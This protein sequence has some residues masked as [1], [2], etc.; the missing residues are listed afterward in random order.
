MPAAAW[1]PKEA[2]WRP[3]RP[4]IP[5]G[6]SYGPLHDIELLTVVSTGT[7]QPAQRDWLFPLVVCHVCDCGQWRGWLGAAAWGATRDGLEPH[8]AT[9]CVGPHLLTLLLL[10][11]LRAAAQVGTGNP[12][13]SPRSCV[14]RR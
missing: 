3:T 14:L 4:P 5:P 10:P 1:G 12:A 9:N 8:L 2:I 7:D 6:R 11:A 13:P